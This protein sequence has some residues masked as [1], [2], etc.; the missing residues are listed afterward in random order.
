MKIWVVGLFRASHE[1]GQVWG[2]IGLFQN[3]RQ[4]DLRCRTTEHFM[5]PF[6]MNG[7]VSDERVPWPDLR[8]PRR[9]ELGTPD[10]TQDEET[11]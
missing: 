2:L 8:W 10:A 11:Y 5:A 4:A 6:T 3:E 1:E 9:E 7:S